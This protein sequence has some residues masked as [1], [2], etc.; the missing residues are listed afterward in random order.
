VTTEEVEAYEKE[1]RRMESVNKYGLRPDELDA[2]GR[3]VGE[4]HGDG[5]HLTDAEVELPGSDTSGAHNT[6]H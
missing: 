4:L 3:Y 5:R 1:M 6:Q 2:S